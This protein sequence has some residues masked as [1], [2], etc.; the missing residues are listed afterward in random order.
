[1]LK[2]VV[3]TKQNEIIDHL[4][5]RFSVFVCE[6]NIPMEL[7]HDSYDELSILFTAYYNTTPCGSARVIL[8]DDGYA[9][10]G[11]VAVIKDFRLMH[12]GSYLVKSCE[13]YIISKTSYRDVLIESQIDA[14]P[15]YENL[16]YVCYGEEFLDASILH[17][18]MKKH[19]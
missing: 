3:A 17:K 10:I 7:E 12:I 6:Q 8:Q 5:V 2:V 19:L 14:I 1:M 13:D 9:K 4:M 15:F 16:G 18:K 11:R